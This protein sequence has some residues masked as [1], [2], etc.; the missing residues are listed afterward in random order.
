MKC[1]DCL[2]FKCFEYKTHGICKHW[3]KNDVIRSDNEACKY[4]SK[5]SCCITKEEEI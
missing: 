1:K 3:N 4:L 2:K 5:R